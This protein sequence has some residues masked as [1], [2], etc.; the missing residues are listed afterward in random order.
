M[1]ILRL[2]FELFV[3]YILYKV[4]FDFIVPI[5]RTTKQMK[6][7]MNDL[8]SRMYEQQQQAARAQ[9]QPTVPKSP[10]KRSSNEDYIEYEEIK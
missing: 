4:I 3:L 6:G 9:Q 2:A 5:Y 7:K 10:E 1:N 8:Q